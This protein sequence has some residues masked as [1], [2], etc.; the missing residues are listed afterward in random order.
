MEPVARWTG[1]EARALRHALR[2]SLRVFAEHLGIGAR[3]VSKWEA[4]SVVCPRPEMQ[5]ILDTA[6]NRAPEDARARFNVILGNQQNIRHPDPEPTL[7]PI[8]GPLVLDDLILQAGQDPQGD[9]DVRRREFIGT[10][11]AAIGLL[12]HGAGNSATWPER[13][14]LGNRLDNRAVGRGDL[15]AVREMGSIF[16]RVDQRRGGGHAR[17]SVVQYL[18]SD[19]ANY[20]R[21]S[22]ADDRV[23]SEMFSAASE[24]AYLSGWMAF[25]NAEHFIAQQYFTIAVALATEA[26][27]PPMSGHVLRAMAHQAVD[28]RHYQQGLE[29]AAASMDGRRYTLACPRERALFGVVYARAL[30]ATG[31]KAAAAAALIRAEDD[32]AATTSD[33]DEPSRVFFFGEASLAHQTACTL[34]DTGDLPGA[35]REFQRSARTRKATIFTRTHALTLG[36]LGSVQALSGNMDEACATWSSALDV[37]DG[38]NSG[39]V[40]QVVTDMRSGLSSF[41]RQGS[42]NT[43]ELD[44]RAAAYLA[45]AP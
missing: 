23:R 29:L 31:Q 25:D 1:T 12:Q 36:S 39:R 10:A 11:V 2:M 35:L 17:T 28:L 33:D 19:V 32:L 4:G 41:R 7:L 26:D 37:M 6:L 22:Y 34:R 14:T 44:A 18:T 38:I 30:G 27:D 43:T 3:T 45:A 24:L 5:A 8:S 20:L 9:A 42:S 21:G 13:V 16:S 40:R 15:D